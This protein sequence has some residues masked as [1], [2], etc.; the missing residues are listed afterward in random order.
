MPSL[1][2]APHSDTVRVVYR[3]NGS[4]DSRDQV[5]IQNQGGRQPSGAANNPPPAVELECE[6]LPPSYE[7]ALQMPMPDGAHTSVKE[8][9]PVY[10]N[11]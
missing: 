2:P 1:F 5:E 6:D 3:R 7:E 4:L 10:A 9:E 11:S 8:E